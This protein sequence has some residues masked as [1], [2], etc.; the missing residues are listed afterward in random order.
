MPTAPVTIER[1]P[2]EPETEPS[3]KRE[4]PKWWTRTP[5]PQGRTRNAAPLE[6]DRLVIA[7][8]TTIT[9]SVY[10][11]FRALA[12]IGPRAE[13]EERVVKSGTF[14]VRPL[15]APTGTEYLSVYLKPSV[16]KVEIR[17]QVVGADLL[18]DLRLVED[19]E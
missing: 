4:R 2:T 13:R 17:H 12:P 11:G 14:T 3:P 1:P 5:W 10:V 19:G 8:S 6:N 16:R 7:N 15:E 9:W 18:Y